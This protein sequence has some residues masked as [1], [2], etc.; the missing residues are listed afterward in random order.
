MESEGGGVG[1]ACD[2]VESGAIEDCGGGTMDWVI[3]DIVCF[4]MVG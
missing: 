3:E 1:S 2:K 4:S